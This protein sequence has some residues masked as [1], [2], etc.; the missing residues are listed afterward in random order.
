MSKKRKRQKVN[1]VAEYPIEQLK[2]FKNHR[3]LGVFVKKGTKCVCC[4]SEGTRLIKRRVTYKNGK[5][6]DHIDLYT[7]DLILMTVDHMLPKSK[8]GSENIKNKQ[9]MCCVCNESKSSKYTPFLGRFSWFYRLE[10][11]TKLYLEGNPKVSVRLK[12]YIELIKSISKVNSVIEN[13]YSISNMINYSQEPEYVENKVSKSRSTKRK[14]KKKKRNGKA[15]FV[16]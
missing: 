5:F 13:A 6:D 4:H 1:I 11:L 8:K 2:K 10:Y 14:K 15:I 3:R 7:K 16:D 9:T 12:K